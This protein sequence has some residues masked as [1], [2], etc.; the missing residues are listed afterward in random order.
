MNKTKLILTLA[1]MSIFLIGFVSA[2]SIDNVQQGKLYPGEQASLDIR[3]KNTLDDS[4]ENVNFHLDLSN[5]KF[6]S[7]GSASDNVDEIQDDDTETFSFNLKASSDIKPGDYNVPYIITYDNPAVNGSGIITEKGS[8]GISV[9]AKTELDYT[10][11][12]ENSI[13]GQ[14]G[15]VS[16]KIINSGLGD[17]KFVNVKIAPSGFTLLGSDENYI[18]TVSS[19]DFETATFDVIFKSE[20]AKLNAIVEYKDFDN[21]K[22]TQNVNLPLTVYS[23]EKALELGIIQKNNTFIYVLVIAILVVAFFIYRTIRKRRKK[24]KNGM[25]V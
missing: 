4:I 7:V 15:K 14:K 11:I 6:M 17:I 9:G 10:G 1:F 19:N 5:S 21:N 24:K 18:G 25:G 20:S 16:L 12:T 8:V 23:Q 3:L 22:I 2:I 13:V